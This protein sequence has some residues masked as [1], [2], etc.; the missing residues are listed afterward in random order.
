MKRR[1]LVVLSTLLAVISLAAIAPAAGAATEAP[2]SRVWITHGLPFNSTGS[3]VDVYVNGAKTLSDFTFGQTVGPLT[4]PAATY[5][6][7]VKLAG[8]D[9]VAIDQKVAVPGG[10][11]FSVVASYIDAAGTLGLNVFSNDLAKV[12]FFAGRLALHHAAAAPAVDVDLGIY[13]IS[14]WF[15]FLKFTAVKGAVNGQSASL[16]VPSFIKYTADVRVSGTQT[17]VLSL[18]K[19]KVAAKTLTNVYVV[20][21]AA[22]GTLQTISST[23]KL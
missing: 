3:N 10:G 13:P 15:S 12:P 1:I 11:N 23:I 5:D 14:R 6:I 19:V 20:G 22:G 21:S 17:T 8:T 9:T 16:V 18:D 4:L 7:Q 2:T